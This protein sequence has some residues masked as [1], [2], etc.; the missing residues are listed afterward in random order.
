LNGVEL[1][2]TSKEQVSAIETGRVLVVSEAENGSGVTVVIEH[3]NGRDSVYGKLGAATV[4]QND[5]VEA[6]DGIGTLKETT[7]EEPSLLYF[8][9]RQNNQYVDPVGVIPID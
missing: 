6:G 9:V 5:W 7:S 3:A 4:K 2:G 8:A 1:A